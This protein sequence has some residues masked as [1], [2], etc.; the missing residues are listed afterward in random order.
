VSLEHR[1]RVQEATVIFAPRR[2]Q[3]TVLD[4]KLALTLVKP[5][6]M[7]VKFV[8]QTLVHVPMVQPPLQK[9]MV[10]LHFAKQTTLWI[11]KSAMITF[12]SNRALDQANSSVSHS[13]AASRF[14]KVISTTDLNAIAI[15]TKG[16]R[17]LSAVLMDCTVTRLNIRALI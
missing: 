8:Y 3:R 16:T 9:A 4:V 15:Y 5:Q 6:G 1:P 11:A 7:G 2:V 12:K 13:L 17:A 10:L 14:L